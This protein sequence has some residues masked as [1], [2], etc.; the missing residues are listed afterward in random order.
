MANRGT[1]PFVCG[2]LVRSQ[3]GVVELPAIEVVRLLPAIE[4]V[5]PVTGKGLIVVIVFV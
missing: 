3:F 2:R 5:L 1:G 4:V